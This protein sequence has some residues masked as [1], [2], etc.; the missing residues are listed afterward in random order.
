MLA[1]QDVISTTGPLT[2]VQPVGDVVTQGTTVLVTEVDEEVLQGSVTMVKC[3]VV[4]Q[5][6]VIERK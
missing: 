4:H 1:D 2:M 3:T 5:T 6:T